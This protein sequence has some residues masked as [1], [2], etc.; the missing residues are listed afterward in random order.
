MG[1]G[2][3]PFGPTFDHLVY[4]RVFEGCNLRCKHCFIPPNPKSMNHDNIGQIP[5]TLAEKIPE[6]SRVLLQ[7]HGGEPTMFG[8]EWMN[9]A[10]EIIENDTRFEW[11]HGIQ[12]NLLT[13]SDEWKDIYK[14]YFGNEVG[15][16]WDPK[17][18]IF[19][20]NNDEK[21][22]NRKYEDI[23]WTNVDKLVSDG[24]DPYLVVTGTKVF[25]EYF[26]NPIDFFELMSSKGIKK[27]HIER[28]TATGFARR[29]WLEVGV[30]NREYS[31]YMSRFAKAYTVWSN[32]KNETGENNLFLSPFDGLFNSVTDK[33]NGK[34]G[35]YGC[36]SGHCD[37][38]FHT[39][40]S[41]G[42]KT[43]C[44]AVNSE[45][46]NKNANDKFLINLENLEGERTERQIYYCNSCDFRTICNTGCLAIDF[47]DGSGECSGGKRFFETVQDIIVRRN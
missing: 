37:T 29:N 15:I 21:E 30:N 11:V 20:G 4:V 16:S 10:L 32:K 17:I 1:E 35:G 5:E 2:N 44:T 28:I 47:D 46:D 36:W 42:Y 45:V 14:K 38:R 31:H 39:I 7:W 25:F 27:A 6:G 9:T 41:N 23:F 8:P 19:N 22:S 26:K 33:L 12:T 3:I 18:R 40:D 43:G 13:Y 24:L 34:S